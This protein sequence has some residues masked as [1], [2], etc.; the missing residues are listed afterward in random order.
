VVTRVRI[1]MQGHEAAAKTARKVFPVA[2]QAG[3]Q[4]TA[5]LLTQGLDIHGKTAWMLRGLLED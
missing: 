4:P 5:D 1:F 3:D 2:E